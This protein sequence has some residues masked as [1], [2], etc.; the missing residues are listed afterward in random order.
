M[1]LLKPFVFIFLLILQI[2]CGINN[3]KIN[4][5]EE[6]TSS[7]NQTN[8]NF[9]IIVYTKYEIPLNIDLYNFL[10]TNN[11]NFAVNTLN[12]ISTKNNYISDVSKA[13]NLGIYTSDLTYCTIYSESQN[14][15]NYFDAGRHLARELGFSEGFNEIYYSRLEKNAENKDSLMRIAEES[16][17]KACN[18]LE[19][20]NKNNI[21]PFIIYGGWIE[22][23]HILVNIEKDS[24]NKELIKK[25]ILNQKTAISN[26]IKYLYDVMI[27]STA[28]YYNTDIDIIIKE[29]KIIEKLYNDYETNKSPKVYEKLK[30]KI[31]EIRKNKI[32]ML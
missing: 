6:D 16:Y 18:Y 9:D 19:E 31:L 11:L 17:W 21:L 3:T 23:L 7:N 12:S 25:Q 15:L 2:S 10:Y 22:A 30:S 4:N 1:R 14:S 32:E 26:V 8:S 28:Y 24:E 13:I 29:L 5:L 20:Q 27:E